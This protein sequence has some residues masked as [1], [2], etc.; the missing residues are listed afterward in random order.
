[1]RYTTPKLMDCERHGP[2]SELFIVEG[3]SAARTIAAVRDRRFQAVLAMQGKPMN[4]LKATRNSVAKN[5]QFAALIEALGVEITSAKGGSEVAPI[6]SEVRYERL[7]LLFDPDADGIHG[8]TLMLFFFYRW[9]R[10]WLEAGRVFDAH[11]PQWEITGTGLS[12]PK[13]AATPDHMSAIRGDLRGQ[14]VTG[15]RVRRYRG[16][17]NLDA[18][19]LNTQCVAPESRAL[20]PLAV[21]SAQA[22]LAVFERMRALGKSL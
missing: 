4:T 6:D 14:G 2:Q 11:A 22:A 17:G 15:I 9:L 3:D 8:R 18:K 19:I 5:L 20:W 1:M 12:A 10:P 7:I 16:L 13:Y 21:S